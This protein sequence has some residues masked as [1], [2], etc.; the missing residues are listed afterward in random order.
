MKDELPMTALIRSHPNRKRGYIK[1]LGLTPEE[2]PKIFFVY[3]NQW[4]VARPDECLHGNIFHEL[5]Q[6]E[7][8]LVK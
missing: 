5:F 1:W 4:L 2:R 3:P 8:D 7:F 6:R